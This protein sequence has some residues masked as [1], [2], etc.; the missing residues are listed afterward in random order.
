MSIT[1]ILIVIISNFFIISLKVENKSKFFEFFFFIEPELNDKDAT[2]TLFIGNLD[3][4]VDENELKKLFDRFGYIEEIDI[5]RI[6][7]KKPYAFIKY[8]NLDMAYN[9]KMEMNDKL[10]GKFEIKIGFG[11]KN[12]IYYINK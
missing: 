7:N 10:I 9:A 1:T 6:P 5:K 11:N 8:I 2:R 12:D 4:D 3:P